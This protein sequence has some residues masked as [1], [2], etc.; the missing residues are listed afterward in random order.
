MGVLLTAFV[1]GVGAGSSRS[2]VDARSLAPSTG[3]LAAT[4]ALSWRVV[5]SP[6]TDGAELF[7]VAAAAPDDAWAVGGPS[8]WVWVT[9]RPTALTEH[10]D[11]AQWTVVPN[12]QVAG[13]LEGVA[14]AAHNDVWAVGELGSFGSSPNTGVGRG[15][16]ALVEHW[17]G[18]EWAQ[19]AVTGLQRLSAVAAASS[20]DVWAVG[21][22]ADGAAVILHWD[23]SQWTPIV[24]RPHAELFA[25]VAISASDVWAV[26]DVEGHSFLEMH[27]DG[28]RWASYSQPAPR[29]S[30]G[31][32]YNPALDA[33]AAGGRND[34]WAAGDAASGDG[35]WSDIIL[36]HWNGTKWRSVPPKVSI[37][38]DALAM[39][40][41]GDVVLAGLE[42]DW[43]GY[44]QTG[45]GPV[46]ERGRDHR[47]QITQL[48]D[49][50]WVDAFAADHAGG[51][52][53]VGFTGSGS[54]YQNGFPA[55]T[56]PMVKR[57]RCSPP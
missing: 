52:W 21:R 54:T 33:V 7:A 30:D 40:A 31:P 26:G 16:G 25:V 12:P 41:P 48:H 44:G 38:V 9:P 15:L 49:G 42:G 32:N 56:A 45:S 36:L 22:S 14:I 19:V 37:W 23:G 10:W 50:Q 57:A 46:I 34:V 2:A 5:P 3:S 11:G 24:R 29:T 27:W 28:K 18:S 39:R 4:C 17:N 20:N 43:L 47:W 53:A 6:A 35:E 55:Q 13:V 1:A 51:L 8:K